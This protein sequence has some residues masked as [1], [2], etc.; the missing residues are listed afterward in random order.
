[1]KL[2]VFGPERR[3]GIVVDDLVIDAAAASPE[4][5]AELGEFIAAGDGALEAARAAVRRIGETSA[6]A[7]S[8]G[9]R[10]MQ[11]LGETVLRPPIAVHARMFGAGNNYAAHAAGAAGS[12]GADPGT[13]D[14]VRAE[15]REIGPRGFITFVE[16]CVGA[17]DDI[18]HPARTE[19]LDFEGEVA[20]VIGSVCKDVKAAEAADVIW[21]SVLLNDVSA[22]GAIPTPDNPT[23]RFAR[24]KNFDS[25]KCIGPY[26]VVGE[27]DPQDIDLETRVNG[28]L[29]QS[30]NTADMIF[31][32]AEIIEYLSEDLTLRP[33]DVIA[34][35]TPSGTVMDSTPTDAEGRRD[36]AAFL[37]VGDVIDVSSPVLGTLR[38]EVVAKEGG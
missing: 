37:K 29:R 11:P 16:N 22:R 15:V 34:G 5:P 36:P 19:M 21:G 20:V 26:V 9:G 31:S 30:G 38:N 2:C 25:S 13:I 17:R 14:R 35:G 7:A 18:V 8:D 4:L 32:F 24:D 33:G 23:S 28:E 3:V 1:V 6:P 10:S 12:V 27:L